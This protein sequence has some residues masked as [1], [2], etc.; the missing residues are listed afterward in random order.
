MENIG[1]GRKVQPINEYLI[2][3]L[4]EQFKDHFFVNN[5]FFLPGR[6]RPVYSNIRKI[7]IDKFKCDV[8]GVA[9]LNRTI[10]RNQSILIRKW[11]PGTDQSKLR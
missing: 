9:A 2:N 3:E 7:L 4:I 11:S 5:K 1:F 10:Y 8:P 6:K